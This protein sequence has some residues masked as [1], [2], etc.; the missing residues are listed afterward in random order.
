MLEQQPR[1]KIT[2]TF[3]DE[4]TH[5]IP[6]NNWGREEWLREFDVMKSIGMD[7]V[8][9]IRA[10]YRNS[11]IFS[12]K[13]IDGFLVNE[14]DLARLFFEAAD[15]RKMKL[16]FGIYDSGRYWMENDWKKEADINLKFIDEVWDR[17]GRHESFYGWYLTHEVSQGENS[18]IQLVTTIADYCKRITPGKSTLISPYYHGAKHNAASAISVAQHEKIWREIFREINGYIDICA[19]Q[20][21]HVHFHE[22]ETWMQVTRHLADE[23]GMTMWSNCESFDRD[24]PIRFLPIDWRK[25]KAK[26]VATCPY[27]EKIITFEFPHFMSPNSLWPSAG[28][29]FRR[30]REFLDE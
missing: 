3:L 12:S 17:Y 30:Y 27:V 13:V 29:L 19:F 14:E 20:D 22:L 5:D 18:Y 25:M 28:N 16:F 11:V 4:I 7:T 6:S 2:G 21:G 23:F 24:M 10:G 26:L 1:P 15:Q 8:I 9:I